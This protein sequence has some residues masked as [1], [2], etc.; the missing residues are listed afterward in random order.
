MFFRIK[1]F[2]IDAKTRL[3]ISEALACFS[4]PL[5]VISKPE[6]SRKRAKSS[7][8]PKK[9]RK[10]P[11]DELLERLKSISKAQEKQT[12]LLETIAEKPAP[13]PP[14]P[15]VE[16]PRIRLEALEHVFNAKTFLAA[17]KPDF[18]SAFNDLISYLHSM[19]A[20][21]RAAALRRVAK[22]PAHVN[23]L[24]EFHDL[25][26]GEGLRKDIPSSTSTFSSLSPAPLGSFFEMDG[27]S[28]MRPSSYPHAAH[29]KTED[30]SCFSCPV[31]EEL[32]SQ[33]SFYSEAF[34]L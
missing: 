8:K 4:E 11:N 17:A 34:Q 6:Q 10:T 22:T 1:F 18:E 33:L 29:V 14:P 23:Q 3:P 27:L 9:K 5:K 7:A 24:V 30:C 21:H 15:P 32:D 20:A 16:P 31:K 28:M 2:V 26:I 19:P 25:L 12:N 13:V